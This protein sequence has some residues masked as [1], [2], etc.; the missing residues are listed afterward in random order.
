[1]HYKNKVWVVT[2][3]LLLT[4]LWS[5]K[6]ND[7]QGSQGILAGDD[8]ATTFYLAG[9]M[10]RAN[11]L[12]GV[13]YEDAAD[14]DSDGI[15]DIKLIAKNEVTEGGKIR[16]ECIV[17]PLGLHVLGYSGEAPEG[18]AYTPKLAKGALIT[19]DLQEYSSKEVV[20]VSKVT[21]PAT[22][23]ITVINDWKGVSDKYISIKMTKGAGY[24]LGWFRVIVDTTYN[25]FTYRGSAVTR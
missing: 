8:N 19:N 2:G 5:C 25:S 15:G 22:N 17:K 16:S 13:T 21:D 10:Y 23:Q 7:I 11:P 1:M 20:L 24:R 3:V 4:G 12:P 9:K 6:K 18:R 14:M